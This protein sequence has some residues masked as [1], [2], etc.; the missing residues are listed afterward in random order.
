MTAE[1]LTKQEA[2]RIR[3]LL[4]SCGVPQDRIDLLTTIIDN[5]AWM[6]IKLDDTREKVKNSSVVIPYDNGGGQRGIRENPLYKG[7]E[8]L[9]KSYVSGMDKLLSFLPKEGAKEAVADAEEPK[10]VLQI[11]RSKHTA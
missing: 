4:F 7:Y 3:D 5:T 2:D 9:F 1:E 10:T 11:I 6:K 8:S